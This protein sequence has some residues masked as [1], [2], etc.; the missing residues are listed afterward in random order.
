MDKG[1][2]MTNELTQ[3]IL[4]RINNESGED[5]LKEISQSAF[6]LSTNNMDCIYNVNIFSN[7][8]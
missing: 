4:K 7:E 8:I 1:Q 5:L 3:E 2:K 6:N